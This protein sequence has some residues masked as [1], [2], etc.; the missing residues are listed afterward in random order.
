M[1]TRLF[2]PRGARYAGAWHALWV[3]VATVSLVASLSGQ[4]PK[5]AQAPQS[6]Q[7]AQQG[8]DPREIYLSPRTGLPEPVPPRGTAPAARPTKPW[9]GAFLPDGQPDVP[10][11]LWNIPSGGT[12]YVDKPAARNKATR[13]ADPPD[14]K[15][16]YQPWALE[17]MKTAAYDLFNP[18]KPWHIDTQHRCV[19]GM[20]RMN[21]YVADYKIYQPP[22][23]VVFK[24][25][26]Y[27]VYRV[28]PL[29]GR[30]HPGKKLK[31]WN[32]DAVGRWEGNTLIVDTTNL[33]AHIPISS[34]GGDFITP[35]TRMR[36]KFT[37]EPDSKTMVWEATFDDSTLLT[38][39][40]TIRV[41]HELRAKNGELWEYQCDIG[42][43]NGTRPSSIAGTAP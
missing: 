15:I 10:E 39:P 1:K 41:I 37:F 6:A 22:G 40:Y 12:S 36:E 17:K 13:I 30:P 16:P 28:I 32:G 11:G 9:T 26:G 8:E 20:P 33:N 19:S 2:R 24:Y 14:G 5:G 25:D 31:L 43:E 35:N 7:V 29:D 23:Y 27:R 21:W 18:T 42:D 3:G 38:R 4:T 34:A